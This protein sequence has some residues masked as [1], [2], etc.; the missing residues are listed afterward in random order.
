MSAL[1][2]IA[3]RAVLAVAVVTAVIAA[4]FIAAP[5]PEGLLDYRPMASVRMTDRRGTLLRE[6]K[7]RDD[8]RAIPLLAEEISLHVRDAFI[9]AEDKG[10]YSHWGLSLSA[11]VRAA[12]QNLKA[13]KVVAGGSTIT[14]QLARN[15][16]KRERTVLGKMSE[17]MW[18]L[19]LE[20]H[21]SKQEILT[22]YLNRVPF[23]NNTFGLEAASQLYFGRRAQHLSLGQA[24]VMASIPRGPSAYNPYRAP[25]KLEARR[26][27]VLSRM[28]ALSLV[29]AEAVEEARAAPLDLEAFRT[30][31]RAPHFVEFV[32]AHLSQW[33]LE[34]ATVVET[35]L[36]LTLQSEVETHV[37]EELN[38]LEERRVSSA[39][40]IVID[41]LNGEVLAY[42]G[43]GDFF[44]E[45]RAG[46]N[47]GLQMKRQPG[48]ALKPFM[49]ALA[50]SKGYTPASV[51]ADVETQF[52]A[53]KGS[54]A[55][56]NYDRRAHGPVRIR[57][58]LANSYNVPAVRVADALGVD[59]T[60]RMFREAGLD[61]LREQASHYGLGLVLGNGEVSLWELSR[62]YSGLSRGGVVRPL[63]AV[64]RA[65]KADGT[66][67]M[68]RAEHGEQRFA[69]ARAVALVTHIL[70]DNGARARAFG[71]DNALRLPFETA[72]KTGTSKG[73]SDNWTVGYTRERTVAVWAGNFD[74]TPMVQVSG[75]TGAGPIF[76]RV[77][78]R[79]MRGLSLQALVDETGLVRASICP[80][81]GHLAGEHCPSAMDERFIAGTQ[82]TQFCAQHDVLDDALPGTLAERCRALQA[83]DGRIVDMGLD[84]YD[85]AQAEG[86]SSEP[87][88]AALCL[89]AGT[90]DN[91]TATAQILLPGQGDDFMVLSDLPLADQ[92]IPLRIR[93]SP[94]LGVLEVW[95]DGVK[96]KELPPP[97]TG[98][99]PVSLGEHTVVLR[100]AGVA[101]ALSAVKYRV[102]RE[103]R[104]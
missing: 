104:F 45:A 13:G 39:A 38:R 76:K 97:Y 98:R 67:L 102:R 83:R 82:P 27:W 71:L 46:Q 61:S 32:A 52:G 91:D 66:E 72:A 95:V 9:A 69:D 40:A 36:D 94:K 42:Q 26:Q 70:S 2:V 64:L 47:D 18:A 48:S 30:A 49:Y 54:Y 78:T 3:R 16:V 41:N 12:Y 20:A 62:A 37:R 4:A 6:L 103:A 89:Q 68:V 57:E 81:S 1:R 11:M 15:V 31:F 17:A 88:L 35:S 75:I 43:S 53:P 14:Q 86:L 50:F 100:K 77:M 24:A 65:W 34:E 44:D 101:V 23:G 59:A 96:W 93:A 7:S 8:G 5:L 33:G 19:R 74:G 51:L 56:K 29:S 55:P 28:Q 63:S 99:I 80:L 22:Q 87:W 10:F 92:A 58:A 25:A 73:Y 21:L 84:Y 60:L 79:A 90:A 85:W